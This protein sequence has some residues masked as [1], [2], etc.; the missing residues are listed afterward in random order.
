MKF[1]IEIPTSPSE[2]PLHRY[3]SFTALTDDERLDFE[4]ILS[5]VAGCT[6][7]QAAQVKAKDVER[8]LSAI[9][10]ALS[11]TTADLLHHYS[12]DGITYGFEPQLDE[13]TFGTMTDVATAFETPETWH[14]A[15]AILYR[16][17]VR[18]TKALGGLYAIEPHKAQSEAYKY[19]QQ[20]FK[21]APTSLFLGVRAFFLNGSKDLEKFTRDSLTRLSESQTKSKG[22]KRR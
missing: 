17:I 10:L 20:I 9:I 11:D 3:Q 19:R 21:D 18:K 15:L 6:K 1:T 13:M 16:P 14:K 4:T 12:H 5:T 7:E 2:M 8:A 22:K